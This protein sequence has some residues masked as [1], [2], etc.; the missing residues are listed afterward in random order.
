MPHLFR[1]KAEA[2]LYANL[3]TSKIKESKYMPYVCR[4]TLIPDSTTIQQVPMI[5]KQ[6]FRII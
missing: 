2:M 3:N 1:T 6:K 5:K 4:F